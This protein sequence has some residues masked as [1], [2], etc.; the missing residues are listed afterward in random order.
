[1][2]GHKRAAMRLDVYADLFEDDLDAVGAALDRARTG[3]NG[4]DLGAIDF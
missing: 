3:I 4:G 2:L 1:M